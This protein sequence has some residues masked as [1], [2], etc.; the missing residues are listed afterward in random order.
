MSMD[1]KI[2]HT[3]EVP[4]PTFSVQ[5]VN[6]SEFEVL[7]RFQPER[8]GTII[9]TPVI[10]IFSEAVSSPDMLMETN[11]QTCA[12]YF[13]YDASQGVGRSAH[14]FSQINSVE[15]EE[16]KKQSE[17]K[18]SHTRWWPFRRKANPLPTEWIEKENLAHYQRYQ[19]FLETIRQMDPKQTEVYIF[20][21]NVFSKS[22]E[23]K[24]AASR[25]RQYTA[26]DFKSLGVKIYDHRSKLDDEEELWKN[27]DV[28]V[29]LSQK[30]ISV[31]I[32]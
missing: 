4:Q 10:N 14:F 22:A 2:L 16:L 15:M 8:E 32:M 12:I 13:A 6:P 30:Q 21:G 24:A 5:M 31:S 25:R 17:I 27:T 23:D 3:P 29:D 1:G 18:P 20:G 7:R 19:E 26:A 9:K 11:A 28:F